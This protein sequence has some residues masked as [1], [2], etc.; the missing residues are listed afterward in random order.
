MGF[1]LESCEYVGGAFHKSVGEMLDG[2]ITQ[3]CGALWVNEGGECVIARFRLGSP[4]EAT[5]GAWR[6]TG[7][8]AAYCTEYVN[9]AIQG[10]TCTEL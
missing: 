7:D 4:C 3:Y 8:V 5:M 10:S 6:C 1:A 2:G 9:A